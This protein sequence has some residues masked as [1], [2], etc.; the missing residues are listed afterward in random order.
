[1]HEGSDSFGEC[2][3]E[4]L[5][6]LLCLPMWVTQVRVEAGFF[7][8]HLPVLLSP[9]PLC[10]CHSEPP[11][12]SDLTSSAA[13]C[14]LLEPCWLYARTSDAFV[15][16]HCE[17]PGLDWVHV[18]YC[19]LF[20]S[21][22]EVVSEWLKMLQRP[23]CN[24]DN[25]NWWDKHAH[26]LCPSK[27]QTVRFHL[28]YRLTNMKKGQRAPLNSNLC[29]KTPQLHT[30]C[31]NIVKLNWCWHPTTPTLKVC[32]N[33]NRREPC[34]VSNCYLHHFLM[35]KDSNISENVFPKHRAIM[36]MWENHCVSLNI[37]D[38]KGTVWQNVKEFTCINRPVFPMCQQIV[39]WQKMRPFLTVSVPYNTLWTD[40]YVKCSELIFHIII[41]RTWCLCSL[42]RALP[43]RFSSLTFRANRVQTLA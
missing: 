14:L 11:C 7:K 8:H 28:C 39:T 9:S 23:E 17:E 20:L 29:L 21:S 2:H 4:T 34:T 3:S 5:I 37:N 13:S 25:K 35:A 27:T 10:S 16:L 1:M 33:I 32:V 38:I 6:S 15:Q 36:I 31:V 19:I 30:L 43:W 12:S 26:W 42:H 18:F 41:Q 24:S 22:L 40:F